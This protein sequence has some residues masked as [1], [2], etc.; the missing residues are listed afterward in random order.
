M[1]IPADPSR[2]RWLEGA[3]S[4]T[5]SLAALPWLAACGPLQ[6]APHSPHYGPLRPTVDE[7][8]GL[9]LLA[10]PEGFRCRSFGWTGDPMDDGTPTPEA[11]DGMAVVSERGGALVLV[12]NHEI[13]G[14]PGAFAPGVPTYDPLAGGGTTTLRFSASQ[15]QWLGARASLAGTSRNCA[16]GPTPWGSWLTCEESTEGAHTGHPRSHGWVFEVPGEGV[17]SAQPLTA[18]GAFVHEAAAVDPSTGVVYLTEDATQSGFYRFLPKAPGRLA[19]G[20]RLQMMRVATAPNAQADA[21]GRQRPVFDLGTG[22]ARGTRW[23][24]DWVDIEEPTRHFQRGT[25][26]GGVS[27][28]G[29]AR[30]GSIVRRGEGCWWGDGKVFFTSTSGGAARQGQ[31]FAFDP[32]EQ[33]LT[34]LFESPGREVLSMPD[35]LAMS[36][37]G[38]LLLCEDGDGPVQHLRGLTPDGVVFPFLAN[39]LDLRP[40]GHGPVRRPSG[41]VFSGDFRRSELVGACFHGEWM[42]FS[43]QRPGVTFAVT[44][45]WERGGL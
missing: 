44:G 35:N 37:R 17:A 11:P 41:R 30:G 42:F 31:V 18:M 21:D 12:R 1:T 36:P 16:G 7:T 27:A 43:V 29:F 8:T 39:L 20:G 14:R 22:F 24:V 2:R 3:L 4:T 33:S 26:E 28:Q 32:R 9:P 13:G 34:L 15:G 25:T 23:S 5:A 10:L 38:G 6:R 19:E 40:Q 45:P